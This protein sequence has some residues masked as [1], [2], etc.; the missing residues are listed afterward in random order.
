[1]EKLFEKNNFINI[2]FGVPIKNFSE[3]ISYLDE[4]YKLFPIYMNYLVK[5]IQLFKFFCEVSVKIL[6]EIYIGN[7]DFESLFNA[8]N[9]YFE[10]I[11]FIQNNMNFQYN[12]YENDMNIETNNNNDNFCLET[13]FNSDNKTIYHIFKRFSHYE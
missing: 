11:V 7:F 3:L 13:E 10:Y 2:N 4:K 9:L 12:N 8:D 5:I 1:M 6:N